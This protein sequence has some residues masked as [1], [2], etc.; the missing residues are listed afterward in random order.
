MVSDFRPADMA[1]GGKGAPLVPYLDYFF[2]RDQ[3]WARPAIVQNI[4]GIANLRRFR[5]VRRYGRVLAFDTGPGN[6][7]IDA[8]MQELFGKR[9]DR[10][11]ESRRRDAC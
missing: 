9:F 1:A 11:G 8:V 2:Y 4:G 6:M 5:R 10:D 7:V 3:R